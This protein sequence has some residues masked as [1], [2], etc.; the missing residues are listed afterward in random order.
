[1]CIFFIITQTKYL[2]SLTIHHFQEHLFQTFQPPSGLS[3]RQDVLLICVKF[4][5]NHCLF[6]VSV[7]F[8]LPKRTLKA[9]YPFL[10]FTPCTAYIYLIN[11]FIMRFHCL[12]RTFAFTAHSA[13]LTDIFIYNHFT[14]NKFSGFLTDMIFNHTNLTAFAIFRIVLRYS[15]SFDPKI[16][17]CRLYAT[18]RASAYTDFKLMRQ[19]YISPAYVIFIIK[20][21]GKCVSVIIAVNTS[22]TFT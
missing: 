9:V 17:Q 8:L 3:Q 16:V 2:S 11:D 10:I 1:M 20:F 22:C 21:C 15:V 5:P 4:K 18:V 19:F 12:K 6:Q 14:V 13:S 7:Q